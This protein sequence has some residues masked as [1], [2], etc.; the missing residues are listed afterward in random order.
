MSDRYFLDTNIFIY[1]H[2]EPPARKGSIARSLVRE[3]LASREG[4][5]SYQVV[6]EFFSVAFGKAKPAMRVL[7]AQHY[8]DTVFRPLLAVPFSVGLVNEAMELRERYRLS[9]YDSLIVASALESRCGTLFT[10]DLQHG[11]K[12]RSLV[13]TNPFL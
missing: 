11:Q 4:I 1:A 5:V 12:F 6:Q 10:E 3:A 13:V 2:V 9:W 7:D 8:L